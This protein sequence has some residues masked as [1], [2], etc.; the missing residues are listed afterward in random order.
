MII[1]KITIDVW[2]EADNEVGS[3]SITI[4]ICP[5]LMGLYKDNGEI[6]YYLKLKSKDGFSFEDKTELIELINKVEKI[7]EQAK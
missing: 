4:E 1:D 2:Q 5:A 6:D 7:A 3:E